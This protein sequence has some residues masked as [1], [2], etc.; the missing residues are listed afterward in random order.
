MKIIY[1]TGSC[2]VINARPESVQ[3]LKDNADTIEKV[4]RGVL[5]IDDDCYVASS[6][7]ALTPFITEDDVKIINVMKKEGFT[8]FSGGTFYDNDMRCGWWRE[9]KFVPAPHAKSLRFSRSD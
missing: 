9:G 4:A 8:D 7:K 6:V 5:C 3:F 1:E 2:I